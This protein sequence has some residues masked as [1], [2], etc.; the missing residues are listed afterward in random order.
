MV[1]TRTRGDVYESQRLLRR[2]GAG[3]LALGASSKPDA[4]SNEKGG[5]AREGPTLSGQSGVWTLVETK[6]TTTRPRNLGKTP[7]TKAM[8]KVVKRITYGRG[9]FMRR[10]PR[11]R[12]YKVGL[13]GTGR[14]R[15]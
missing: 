10:E 13:K 14:T 8:S 12:S 6:K 5:K 1:E 11:P 15:E 9:G 7:T 3:W 2:E 4:L